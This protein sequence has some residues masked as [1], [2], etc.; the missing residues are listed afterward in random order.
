M[1]KIYVCLP[2]GNK[3]L[4]D[5]QFLVQ[6]CDCDVEIVG[7]T[8]ADRVIREGLTSCDGVIVVL[9]GSLKDLNT[10]EPGVS[11]AH[12]LGKKI[13]SIWPPKSPAQVIPQILEKYGEGLLPWDAQKLC[14]AICGD[15][16]EWAEA[17]GDAKRGRKIKRHN[18]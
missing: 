11:F 1:S 6:Q 2:I 7:G 5:L 13:I 18:C 16:F 10:I 14:A 8:A 12:K 17:G 3:S 4:T 15:E 9:E